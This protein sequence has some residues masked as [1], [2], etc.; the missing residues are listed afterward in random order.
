MLKETC[1]VSTVHTNWTDSFFRTR[2]LFSILEQSWSTYSVVQDTFFLCGF[3]Y[4]DRVCKKEVVEKC[5]AAVVATCKGFSSVNRLV[6]F[7]VAW[8]NMFNRRIITPGSKQIS[9]FHLSLRRSQL[10]PL[11]C[12]LFNSLLLLSTN[13]VFKILGN[14]RWSQTCNE[15]AKWVHSIFSFSPSFSHFSTYRNPPFFFPLISAPFHNTFRRFVI[16][17]SFKITLL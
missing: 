9:S 10:N 6:T 3:I 2:K 8:A 5:L 13:I 11:F 14:E 1:N 7:L 15:S 16:F 4:D 12:P 17:I